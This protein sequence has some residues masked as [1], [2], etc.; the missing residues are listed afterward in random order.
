MAVRIFHQIKDEVLSLG[1]YGST[2]RIARI[3]S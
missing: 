2:V 1:L 3:R